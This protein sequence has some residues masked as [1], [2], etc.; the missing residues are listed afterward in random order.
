MIIAEIFVD[1]RLLSGASAKNREKKTPV[2][3]QPAST[4]LG[5]CLRCIFYRFYHW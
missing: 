4:G 5:I 2:L 1:T 3:D